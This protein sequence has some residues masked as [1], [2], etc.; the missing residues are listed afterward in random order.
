MYTSTVHA[1]VHVFPTDGH[2]IWKLTIPDQEQ[3]SS[4][5][6]KGVWSSAWNCV[7]DIW[8]AIRILFHFLFLKWKT[9]IIS[10]AIC[11]SYGVGRGG[12]PEPQ[13]SSHLAFCF[14][15]LQHGLNYSSSYH[16]PM[17]L[18]KMLLTHNESGLVTSN[19]SVQSPNLGFIDERCNTLCLHQHQNSQCF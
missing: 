9:I 3:I 2:D 7:W 16:M 17:R 18:D 10:K 5:E 12:S 14:S 1:A 6:K 11:L 4:L 13:D 15:V 19:V 8:Q